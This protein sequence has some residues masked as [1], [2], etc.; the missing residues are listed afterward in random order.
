[1]LVIRGV[2]EEEAPPAGGRGGLGGGKG[3]VFEERRW[4][5]LG[6]WLVPGVV[7]V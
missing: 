2:I 3:K 6:G 4:L 7:V 5:R 1:M